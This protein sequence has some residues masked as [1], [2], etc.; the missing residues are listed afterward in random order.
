[1]KRRMTRVLLAGL[2]VVSVLV[3]TSI[4]LASPEASGTPEPLCSVYLHIHK[5]PS[6]IIDDGGVGVETGD[7]HIHT[8][9]W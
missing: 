9:C 4:V 3:P 1:M 2:M 6:P 8:N 7:Y 5:A